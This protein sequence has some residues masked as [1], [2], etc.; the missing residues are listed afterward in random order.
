[1]NEMAGVRICCAFD[2]NLQ[3]FH[4]WMCKTRRVSLFQHKLNYITFAAVFI[5]LC[6]L[7][8]FVYVPGVNTILGGSMPWGY[9]WLPCLGAGV[10]IWIYNEARKWYIRKNSKTRLAKML[11]WWF[12]SSWFTLANQQISILLILSP[13]D[14]S[15]FLLHKLGIQL[16]QCYSISFTKLSIFRVYLYWLYWFYWVSGFF[17][18]TGFYLFFCFLY[19]ASLSC[20]ASS[21]YCFFLVPM[22]SSYAWNLVQKCG[23]FYSFTYFT[24]PV[25]VAWFFIA[26]T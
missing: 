25:S 20:S 10:F 18:I 19:C 12:Y 21:Q 2:W 9:S 24:R 15:V 13:I 4:V 16:L 26:N 11:Y 23:C 7:I 5:E 6:M 22:F 14:F 1:M 8:I 17:K 3:V